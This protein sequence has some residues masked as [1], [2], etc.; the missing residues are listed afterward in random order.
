M[1]FAFLAVGLNLLPRISKLNTG[2]WKY[3]D[4]KLTPKVSKGEKTEIITYWSAKQIVE[5][6]KFRF[7]SQLCDLLDTDPRQVTLPF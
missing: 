6:S 1:T 2:L 5:S 4:I 7:E 3:F